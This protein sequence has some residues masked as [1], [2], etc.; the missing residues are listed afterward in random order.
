M[1]TVDEIKNISFKKS[2]IRGYAHEEVDAF[3][4]EVIETVEQLRKDKADLIRKMD[5]LAKRVE[6]YRADEETVR[7]ALLSSQ[8]VADAAIR[9][10]KAKSEKIISDAN[11]EA[12]SI[13]ENANA[14]AAMQ[15]ENYTALLADAVKLKE[16]LLYVY[17]KHISIIEELPGEADLDAKKAEVD[18]KY[19]TIKQSVK[20]KEV[21]EEISSV[22]VNAEPQ[23]T[24]S[25]DT[26][27]YDVPSR[28]LED[29]E[30]FDVEQKKPAKKNSKFDNLKFGADYIIDNE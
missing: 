14:V 9:D 23:E 26:I 6:Q 8:R 25:T 29:N 19:P 20:E 18:K 22:S 24:A 16:E 30:N 13:I 3:I 4:D 21:A 5:I 27:V 1:L 17:K 2:N 7:N 15:K 10:A 11:E 12:N 28:K